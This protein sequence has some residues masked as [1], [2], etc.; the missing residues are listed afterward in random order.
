MPPTGPRFGG[1]RRGDGIRDVW[2]V[3]APSDRGLRVEAGP[4][5]GAGHGDEP[6]G[7]AE[8]EGGD[9]GAVPEHAQADQE[10]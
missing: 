2:E 8:A 10:G 6:E 7:A 5:R 1:P 3:L 9:V 4:Q